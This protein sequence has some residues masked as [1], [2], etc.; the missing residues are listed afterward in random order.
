MRWG[1]SLLLVAGLAGGTPL[2]AAEPAA[3]AKARALYNAAN[4]NGAIDA[5]ATVRPQPQWADAATLVIARSHLERFRQNNDPRDLATARE[6]LSTIRAAALAPRDQ[7]DLIVGLG[8]SL[9]LTDSFGAAAEVFETALAHTPPLTGK[10]RG[11]LLDWWATALDREA[12]SRPADRRAAAFTRLAT[13]METELAADA[14]SRVA[15]YWLVLA[16]RGS[17]DLDRAWD[18]AIAGWVRANLTPDREALRA[19]LDRVV[20]TALVP[21]RARQRPAREQAEALNAL[22]AEWDAITQSWK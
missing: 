14:G 15:N 12:Q 22:R 6:L 19:D 13:R 4:Y 11:L 1:W 17:G 20:T 2:L 18:A 8:Q 3:L 16:A 7:V 9:F 10:D 21:E 5:A